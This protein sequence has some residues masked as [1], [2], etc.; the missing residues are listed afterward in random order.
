MDKTELCLFCHGA[1]AGLAQTNVL[2]GTLRT[3][4]SALRGGGFDQAKMNTSSSAEAGEPCEQCEWEFPIGS[5]PLQAVTSEHTLGVEATVW[6]SWNAAG[7][8]AEPNA[9]DT[10]T[11]LDCVS[12]HDPHA[13][14]QTYRMLTRRPADSGVAKHP[15][16]TSEPWEQRVLVTDQLEYAEHYP[17]SDILSYSTDDYSNTKIGAKTWDAGNGTWVVEKTPGTSYAAPDVLDP[18][19]GAPLHVTNIF[20][21]TR[22]Y[23]QQLTEWCASCHDRYHAP[24]LDHMA[25]GSVDSGDAIFSYQHKTGDETPQWNGVE[26]ASGTHDGGNATATLVDSGADFVTDGVVIG[27]IV[28]NLTDGSDGTATAVAA[29]TIDGS[30]EGGTDNLWDEGDQYIVYDS[31]DSKWTTTSCGYGCHSSRQLNCLGCHVAHGTSAAMT[32]IIAAMPW[33]GT[34]SGH[35]DTQ[36][37]GTKLG[38]G[39][40][41]EDTRPEFTGGTDFDGELRSNLL[42]LDNRGVCQNPGC[43]PK[44]KASYLE[45]YDEFVEAVP[46]YEGWS[47]Y[48][49]TGTDVQVGSGGVNVEFGSVSSDGQTSAT[50]LA[51][52][53]GGL[54]PADFDVVGSFWDVTTT[55]SYSGTITLCF[56]YDPSAVCSEA[57]LAIFHWDG[58]QWV[59]VTSFVDT[60]SHTVC[61]EVSSLSPFFVAGTALLTGDQQSCDQCHVTANAHDAVGGDDC[62]L[63]HGG[64]FAGSCDSC[65][66]APPA[67]GAHVTHFGGDASQ[68]SYG[69][70]DNVSSAS[71]YIFE[72][73]TCHSTDSADHQNGTVD[74]ELYSA[75]APPGSLKGMNPPSASYT[76]GG[77]TYT[78]ADG[79]DYTL[80]TCADVYCHS[81]TDWSAPGPVGYPLTD[82]GTGYVMLDANGNLVYDPYVVNE[83]KVYSSIGWGDSS[84]DCNGCHRNF[85]QTAD[86][87]QGGNVVR[88][89][90]NNHEW[91]G[92]WGYGNYHGY[93]MGFDALICRTCHYDTVT[94]DQTWTRDG[95]DRHTYDDVPVANKASHA[96]GVKDVVFDPVNPVVMNTS[97]DLSSTTYD[98]DTKV[99]S[100]VP[101]HLNQPNPE[102][103]YPY[104]FWNSP[105]CD[106][107]HRYGGA[108]WPP[109]YPWPPAG[110]GASMSSPM[111][112]SKS[113]AMGGPA[114][115]P[116]APGQECTQCHDGHSQGQ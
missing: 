14:G 84:L 23:S 46:A 15:D 96:N 110:E 37:G 32:S 18:D 71:A 87:W 90:G 57:D 28:L 44:G 95:M 45:P 19:T 11:T 9:G 67:T 72:C 97:W 33:P 41:A 58:V 49:P 24:Q 43:H 40:L 13:Y 82:P 31:E 30:L 5:S 83:F 12:C 66:G 64:G 39:W 4:T 7:T 115:H 81:K 85:P 63:C 38:E 75:S 114:G 52:N 50:P 108:N 92:M 61:A 59:N 51:G 53:P 48:T 106:Q 70:I 112:S 105:E 22:M 2:E 113:S 69:G 77:T 35:Y 16:E 47:E 29:T 76:P 100:N 27:D 73:G 80:G 55:A 36:T 34:D 60:G 93:N 104:D 103:G 111:T 20:G 78:D 65:H 8:P 109:S 54:T 62:A 99:C 17:T 102:W 116:G 25:P 91:V 89:V 26:L 94:Q 79:I 1:S 74:I 42:R 3:D 107:C 88:G 21:A 10:N 86:P 101:C 68:A 56:E 6:G 98:L